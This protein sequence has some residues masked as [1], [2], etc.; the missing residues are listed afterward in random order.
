MPVSR[1]EQHEQ[2]GEEHQQRAEIKRQR[3]VDQHAGEELMPHDVA[4]D[5]QLGRLRPGQRKPQPDERAD[6]GDEK[7]A[8]PVAAAEHPH[9]QHQHDRRAERQLRAKRRQADRRRIA[10][11]RGD[12]LRKTGLGNEWDHCRYSVSRS[13]LWCDSCRAVSRFRLALGR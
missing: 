4:V 6:Q 3:I 5:Q 2:H 8:A 11:Q 13:S 10:Q 7:R 9:Q 1:V 12:K